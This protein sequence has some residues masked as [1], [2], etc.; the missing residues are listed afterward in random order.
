MN[1]EFSG[2]VST[3]RFALVVVS[4]K[5][6]VP[7]GA[8]P[9]NTLLA[10]SATVTFCPACADGTVEVRTSPAGALVMVTGM[11]LDTLGANVASPA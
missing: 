11:P 9:F 8:N 6:T 3:G 10:A 2:S 1:V 4:V 7:V 5:T